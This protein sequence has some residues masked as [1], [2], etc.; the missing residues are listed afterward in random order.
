AVDPLSLHDALP[1]LYNISNDTLYQTQE[2]YLEWQASALLMGAGNISIVLRSR[3]YDA[4]N[5]FT[6]K[7]TL[8]GME[9]VALNPILEN[10]AFISIKTGEIEGL[11]FDI[12]ANNAGATGTMELRYRG[13]DFEVE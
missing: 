1:I 12:Y 2:G 11:E 13:L 5:A 9:A 6:V 7:G 8:W 3:I 10:N 4:Q